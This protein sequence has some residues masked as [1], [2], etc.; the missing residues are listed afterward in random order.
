MKD[1]KAAVTEI[2]NSFDDT[3]P[4]GFLEKYDQLE[5]L[6]SN[7]GTETFLVRQKVSEQLFVAKCYN[8]DLYSTVHESG[9]LKSL[10]HSG[11]PAFKDEFQNDNAICIVREYIA[12]EPLDKYILENTL[13]QRE[14]TDICI[15]LCDILI[16]LHGQERP[17]IHR[18]IKPQNIIVKPD[19]KIC[20]IDFDIARV[21]H[22]DTKRDTQ[23]FGTR[24]YAPPEQYGFSQSD[25]RT[26]I[27]A[28]GIVLGWLLTGETDAKEVC[29]KAGRN[30]LL[31]IYKKCTAFSPEQRYTSAKKLKAALTHSYG[32]RKTTVLRWTGVFLSCFLSLC[33]GFVLGRFTDFPGADAE[34]GISFEEPLIEQAVRLQLGKTE[35]EAISQDDLLSVS[36]LFIFGDSLIASN[37]EELNAGVNK[38]FESNQVREGPIRSLAD[39]EKMPN[40]KH[41]SISMQKITDISP[42]ASLQ[43]LEK[44]EIKNNPVVDIS[45]LSG[46]KFLKRVSIFDTRVTDFSPLLNCPMLVE[47]D[48][49]KL[50]IRS[51]EAFYGFKGLR[52]LSLHETTIDTL[53]GIDM[54]TQLQ[55]FEVTGVIDGDLSPLLS[56]PHLKDVVLGEDMR[57]AAEAIMEKA[58]FSISYM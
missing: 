47:L 39:L 16:Y 46:L 32:K 31:G 36:E 20:L 45:F 4:A 9:I 55:Y 22:C 57:Q 42:L 19:D 40:L 10:K 3:Y 28:V 27:Y 49:G 21:Y 43:Y 53:D 58:E 29:R 33:A 37:D 52:N 11:L 24:E 50:P 34:P 5:C 25:A 23:F 51:L 17:I 30:R 41:I 12:G 2:L 8:K 6:A 1:I 44:V 48:A 26:D 7:R 14:I 18:D 38:L 54:L 35:N 15:Q 13:S 56:L